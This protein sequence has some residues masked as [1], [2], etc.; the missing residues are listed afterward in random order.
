MSMSETPSLLVVLR[1]FGQ[2]KRGDIVS[3]PATTKAVLDGGHHSSVVQT[4]LTQGENG[5]GGTAE[6]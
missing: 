5:S 4:F 6:H 3:D 1:P 2:Y